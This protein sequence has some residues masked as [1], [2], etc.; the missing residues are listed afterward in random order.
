MIARPAEARLS[1]SIAASNP[2]RGLATDSAYLKSILDQIEGP[3][4]LVGHSYGGTVI[5]NAATGNPN[6]KSL[7]Y[8]AAFAPAEGETG[9]QLIAHAP[10]HPSPAALDVRTSVTPDGQ[11]A[12]E[13]TAKPDKLRPIFAA[14]LPASLTKIAAASQRPAALSTRHRPARRPGRRSPRGRWSPALTRPSAPPTSGTWPSASTPLRS[15]PRARR[16]S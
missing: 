10:E 11:L 3:L 2:L 8:V 14:D 4:V 9:N 12:P 15:K 6:V 5:T 7:V 1:P 16:T 13:V